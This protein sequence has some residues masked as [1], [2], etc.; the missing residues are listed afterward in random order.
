MKLV[1][2]AGPYRSTTIYGTLQNIRRAEE[3]ALKYWKMGY[4]VICPHMNTRL[5]DGAAPDSVWL[6]GDLEILSRC[7]IIVMI[8][9]WKK[10]T[11]SINEL[12]HASKLGLEVIYENDN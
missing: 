11:G 5:F 12:K 8:S 3:V 10:S 1:Y 6:E 7:D 9:G 4:A 2:I